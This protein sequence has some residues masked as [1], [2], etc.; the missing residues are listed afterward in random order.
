MV[1]VLLTRFA[2]RVM[3]ATLD[4]VAE[5]RLHLPGIHPETA[6]P[7]KRLIAALLWLFA[8]VVSYPYLPGSHTDAFKGVSV[9]LGLVLS[10]GSSGLV[11][12]M[13]S[14]F[15]L[16]FTRAIKAGDYIKAGD[17]E[18][19]VTN[20]GLLSTKLRTHKGEE[21]ILPNAVAIGGTIV[22][23]SR[24]ASSGE[25]LL[26]TSV[27]IGYDTPWRQVESLLKAAAA[28]TP[29]LSPSREPFVLQRELADFYVDYQLN[30]VL[31][32]PEERVAALSALHANIQDAFNEAGVQI[33]S[34]HYETDPEEPKLVRPENA[35]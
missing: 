30:A 24:Y 6:A 29:G 33:M 14:G 11:T 9:F 5:G 12:H 4:G 32:Q 16:T 22:N 19:M 1:I 34:P 18:G 23:Y 10:I 27:T 35:G 26:Y 17:T 25:L 31:D 7:S 21:V 8:I 2:I 15:L 3:Q 13:M 20:V 28:R